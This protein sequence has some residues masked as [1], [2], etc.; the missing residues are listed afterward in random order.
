MNI[1]SLSRRFALK[2]SKE[3]SGPEKPWVERERWVTMACGE[4]RGY[5]A[6]QGHE[7]CGESSELKVPSEQRQSTDAE[8]GQMFSTDCFHFL[9]EAGSKTVF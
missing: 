9:S 1:A 2:D 3:Q 5:A 8:S 7:E 6:A 4:K